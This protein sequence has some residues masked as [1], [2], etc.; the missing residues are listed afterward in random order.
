MT[1]RLVI[2]G[3]GGLAR[4]FHDIVESANVHEQQHG[5]PAI[6]DF[7]GF[8]DANAH[9]DARVTG[10]APVLGGDAV[11]ATLPSGTAFIVAIADTDVRRRVAVDA[12]SHGLTPA[13]VV[14]PRALV[15]TR[16]VTLGG[17]SV[18][19]ANAIITTDV[20]V[21][22][23]VHI[24][25]GVQ[26]GHDCVLADFVSLYPSAAIAGAVQIDAGA[27]VGS[28]STVIQGLRIGTHAFVGAG[29]VV[30]RDVAASTTVVGVPA[31]P[32]AS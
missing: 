5:R 16:G 13:V 4:E 28:N 22:Q 15:G 26:V 9:D 23:H 17:G 3:A 7:L 24:D 6:W 19:A 25:R 32:V 27:T 1:T 12:E 21:G 20:A 29:A 2:L 14:H 31:K 18:V 11:L 8:I 30:V 10:R